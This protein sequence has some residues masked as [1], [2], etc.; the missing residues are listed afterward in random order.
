[1]VHPVHL[2]N[3]TWSLC[4]CQLLDQAD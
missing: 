1:M 3:I 2:I 4:G